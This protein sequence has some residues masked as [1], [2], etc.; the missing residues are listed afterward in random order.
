MLA[1]PRELDRRTCV[2]VANFSRILA[3]SLV[4][5]S[6][7]LANPWSNPHLSSRIRVLVANPRESSRTRSANSRIRRELSRIRRESACVFSA[8][9]SRILANPSR[10][11]AYLPRIRVWTQSYAPSSL[12]PIRPSGAATV[13]MK[14]VR[15]TQ[16]VPVSVAAVQARH[17]SA[18]RGPRERSDATDFAHSS[19]PIYSRNQ[20]HEPGRCSDFRL[21][22]NKILNRML[23]R[24]I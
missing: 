8:N 13:M 21:R 5:F 10:I 9:P 14:R 16:W 1:N 24:K 3:N 22:E 17:I 19:C 4:N 15:N 6:I 11:L 18:S 23:K 20:P 2:S 12:K 7:I